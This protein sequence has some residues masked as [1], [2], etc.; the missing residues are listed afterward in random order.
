M[1]LLLVASSNLAVNIHFCGGEISSINFLGKNKDCGSCNAKGISVDTQPCCKNIAAVITVGDT[2]ASTFSFQIGQQS[3]AIIPS[4][5]RPLTATSYAS[6]TVTG[7]VTY[8]VS[9]YLS[10]QPYYILY[11]SLII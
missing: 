2:T 11:R 5:F 3:I 1:L 8:T 9:S 6:E 10:A 4:A 7:A